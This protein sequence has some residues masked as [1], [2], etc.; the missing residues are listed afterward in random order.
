MSERA[1]RVKADDIELKLTLSAKLLK[2]PFG[3]AVLAPFTKAY[4]K[5]K[6]TEWTV[7][8][9][10]SVRVD[11]EYMTDYSLPA[12]IVLL[13]G[14]TVLA[15]LMYRVPP[16]REM[17][18]DSDPFSGQKWEPPKADSSSAGTVDFVA[19]EDDR[20]EI[21]KIKAERRAKRIEKEAADKEADVSDPAPAPAA[22]APPPTPPPAAED[23][24]AAASASL[25]R[26]ATVES[27]VATLQAQVELLT[28]KVEAVDGPSPPND[29]EKIAKKELGDVVKEMHEL[30]AGLDE[31]SL[32]AI[33]KEEERLEARTRKKH[34]ATM[35]E[36]RLLPAAK[37]LQR[38]LEGMPASKPPLAFATKSWGGSGASEK[39]APAVTAD[40]TRGQP[41]T[42]AEIDS[43]ED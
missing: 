9:L 38:R 28:C 2:K 21:E 26:L 4:N 16:R 20:S 25:E 35:L 29:L 12:S 42:S 32:F 33:T 23:Q 17:M 8:D 3:D 5:K 36:S 14:E 22:A 11:D 13:A 30:L 6:G 41:A 37:T 34:A 43:D 39:A 24:A 27:S 7:S 18:L 1:V 31:I 10:V 19:D 15:E 40:P